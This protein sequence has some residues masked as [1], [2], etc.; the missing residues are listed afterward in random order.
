[1]SEQAREREILVEE[2]TSPDRVSAGNPNLLPLNGHTHLTA[3]FKD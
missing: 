1:M 3:D 2:E